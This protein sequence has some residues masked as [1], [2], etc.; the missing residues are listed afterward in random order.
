[1]DY[2]VE[3]K[4]SA[5]VPARSHAPSGSN[6]L[7][8][9]GHLVVGVFPVYDLSVLD[10]SLPL[11]MT[12]NADPLFGRG[13]VIMKAT[14]PRT[15]FVIG[16]TISVDLELQ[17]HSNRAITK[18]RIL[19]E[20][21]VKSTKGAPRNS[22]CG[23]VTQEY[24]L[25]CSPGKLFQSTLRFTF[26]VITPS[27]HFAKFFHFYYALTVEVPASLSSTVRIIL[28]ITLLGNNA[29]VPSEWVEPPY[30]VI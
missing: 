14:I 16:E 18:C 5:F 2:R 15:I 9:D 17:N 3:Y 1:M 29:G 4:V 11:T 6:P 8:L 23:K 27:I 24:A 30:A 22:H 13:D 25:N 20:A 28:P 7:D 19:L 26:P 12:A 10:N 21:A